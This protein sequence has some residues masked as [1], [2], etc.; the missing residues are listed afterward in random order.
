M[1]LKG[2]RRLPLSATSESTRCSVVMVLKGRRLPLLATLLNARCH[3]PIFNQG[4]MTQPLSQCWRMPFAVFP[5]QIRADDPLPFPLNVGERVK[6]CSEVT[7]GV[8][9]IAHGLFAMQENFRCLVLLP[10]YS[11][12]DSSFP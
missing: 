6:S 2:T 3:V 11:R 9:Q 8:R 1:V 5:N 4:Q 7:L 12:K 10:C